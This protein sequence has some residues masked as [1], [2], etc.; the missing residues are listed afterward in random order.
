M[1]LEVLRLVWKRTPNEGD[2]YEGDAHEDGD[3]QDSRESGDGG[4][5]QTAHPDGSGGVYDHRHNHNLAFSSMVAAVEIQNL[6]CGCLGMACQ[7]VGDSGDALSWMAGEYPSVEILD[8]K[9]NTH[10]W[11]TAFKIYQLH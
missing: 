4:H 9:V 8:F 3:L 7:I 1:Q 6:E 10:V 5:P 11:H 2:C